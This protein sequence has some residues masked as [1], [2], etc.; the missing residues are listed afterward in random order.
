MAMDTDQIDEVREALAAAETINAHDVDVTLDGDVV[1]LT[2]AVA[3]FEESSAA[4]QIASEHADQVRSELRVDPNVREG[5]AGTG[6]DFAQEAA[7]RDG[8]RGSSF[9]PLEQGD[10]V[11]TD[12][13]EALE[14]NVPWE[15]PHEA[16]EVPTR[17]ESRGT[18]D[19]NTAPVGE[20]DDGLLDEPAVIE[21]SLPDLTAEDLARAARPAPRDEETG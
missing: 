13:Q 4:M 9:D 18:A 21:K 1:V 2:G 12:M 7:R 17:A 16:V 5:V 19:R 15:P 10:D 3:T 6:E 11:V 8:L 20:T 14:E